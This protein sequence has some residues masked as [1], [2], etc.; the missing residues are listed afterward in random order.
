M[1]ET[2]VIV[3]AGHASGQ[4]ALSLRSEGFDGKIILIGEEPYLPYQRPPLSKKFLAGE[5]GIDRVEFKGEE[6]YGPDDANVDLKLNTTVTA[7]D[8]AGKT[9]TTADGETI[10][11]DKLLL[12]TGSRVRRLDMLP[13][14]DLEGVFYL[15]NIADVEGIQGYFKPGKKAV[16]IGAGYIGLEVAAVSIKRDVSVDVLEMEDRVMARVTTPEVSAFFHKVHSDEGVKLHYNTKVTGFEGTDGKLTHVLTED[17]EKFEAD[18]VVIGV[19]ILPN[20]ELAADAG[21]AC[22]NGILVDEFARTD[23]VNIFAAGDCTNHPNPHLDRNI[24]LESV[25]NALE[26]AKTAAASMCGNSLPYNQVPWF[27]SDQY[28]LKLQTVGLNEG[29]DQVVMRGDPGSRKFAAFYLKQGELIAVDAINAAPEFLMSKRLIAGR[30]HIDPARLAD[31]NI[32]MKE[33]V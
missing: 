3:G 21:I 12:T 7:I 16:I 23:D 13:G 4:A 2:F 30:A 31:T 25:H 1:S 8:R 17:G 32:P 11:Y 9:V 26:Q 18:F 27:W 10:G 29:Y 15:R 14:A 22:N 19:G 5:I 20:Q 6:F 33:M 28:D 24:R